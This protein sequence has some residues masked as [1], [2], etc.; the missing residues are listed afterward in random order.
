MDDASKQALLSAL[1]SLLIVL[2]GALAAHG[3]IND[4]LVTEL[5]GPVMAI[6]PIIWGIWDKYS[7]EKK[8]AA[9]EVVA[10]NSGIVAATTGGMEGM[11]SKAT[12][13]SIIEAFAPPIKKEPTL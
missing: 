6:I 9:R 4:T 10:V 1:R 7:A 8:T 13:P 11:A 3:V 2:G 5:V 12:A